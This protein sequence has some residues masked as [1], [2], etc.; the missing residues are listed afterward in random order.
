MHSRLAAAL[1]LAG[2]ACNS[3]APPADRAPAA[4]AAAVDPL[5]SWTDGP[6]KERIVG[7]VKRVTTPG[8]SDFV[9][10]GDRI[11]TFDNDG[12]LW[13]EQPMYVELFFTIDR[14]KELLPSHPEWKNKQPFKALVA[15]DLKGVL[16]SGEKGLAELVAVTHTGMTVDQF[17]DIVK[18]W[19]ATAKHPEKQMYFTSMTYQPQLDLLKYLRANGFKTFIVSGGGVE[20]MRAFADS[21]YGVPTEQTIGSRGKLKYATPGGK[22]VIEKLPAVDLI[23]NADGKPVGIEEVI[24]K[25]PIIAVGNSDGDYQMLD[26]TTTSG[27]ARLGIFI[28]HDDAAR[29]Y[30]YDRDS[31][32]GTLAMGLDSAAVKEWLV[33]SMKN[34]WK[35]IYPQ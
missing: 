7:F 14:V 8:T 16:A 15:G 24:G 29:E 3:A 2:A 35:V 12:T 10:E 11:A 34:D 4:P 33:V 21:S 6:A 30:A 18:T 1:L 31:K 25:R 13:G 32:I 26:Y 20:F 22:G 19:I 5:P 28:H 27:G 9:A 17:R 23:D